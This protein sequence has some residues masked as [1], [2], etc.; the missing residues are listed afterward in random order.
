METSVKRVSFWSRRFLGDSVTAIFIFLLPILLYAHLWWTP[1]PK[2][3]LFWD[4]LDNRDLNAPRLASK[5]KWVFL[6]MPHGLALR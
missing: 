2:R 5:S 1:I 3:S 4:L 6:S